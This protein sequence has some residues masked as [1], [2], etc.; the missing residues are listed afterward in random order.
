MSHEVKTM[1]EPEELLDLVDGQDHIIGS[2]AR[3][4]VLSLEENK[5]GFTRAVGAFLI[6]SENKLWIPKRGLHKKIAPGGLDFSA[7]EHVGHREPYETAVLRG[8]KEELRIDPDRQKL[9]LIGTVPPFKGMPYFHQIFGYPSDTIPDF[10]QQDYTSY[11]WLSPQ[12]AI[13]ALETGEPAKEILLPSVR[14][15]AHYLEHK[16]GEL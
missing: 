4:E 15:V 1:D 14:L 13:D 7:G 3:Q 5:L 10:N 9:Y 12:E 11:S 8:L 6:N 16:E 2:I